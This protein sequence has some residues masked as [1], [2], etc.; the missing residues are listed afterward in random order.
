MSG[1]LPE[2]GRATESIRP[3]GGEVTAMTDSERS[4]NE[5][6]L[7]DRSHLNLIEATVV[8]LCAIAG[9]AALY[10]F[11]QDPTIMLQFGNPIP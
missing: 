2:I 7:D 3:R 5:K 11:I 10:F 8:V 6:M 1:H 4:R 9:T